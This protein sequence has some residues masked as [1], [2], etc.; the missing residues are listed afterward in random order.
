[1]RQALL[2]IAAVATALTVGTMAARAADLDYGRLPSDRYSD[3]YE[4][5]RYRDLYAPEPPRRY[6]AAPQYEPGYDRG[7]PVPPG[8]VYR[9]APPRYGQTGCLPREAVRERL[10]GEG[11][12]DFQGLGLRGSVARIEARRPN[13]D[14]Y[15]LNVD[16]CSGD[17]VGSRLIERVGARP[18]AYD[19]G[20][21]R[22]YY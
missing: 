19:D 8:S 21:R 9:D 11:W 17:I 20:Q 15:A 5:P 12:R 1:M 4:D 2:I 22:P 16:R 18:Y 3:A 6:S 13:G 10:L 14:R 7:H